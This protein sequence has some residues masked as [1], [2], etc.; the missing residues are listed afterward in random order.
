LLLTRI[1]LQ[2]LHLPIG[3]LLKHTRRLLMPNC[4]SADIKLL[5][6]TCTVLK[7]TTNSSKEVASITRLPTDVLIHS[8]DIMVGWD[9]LCC[10]NGLDSKASMRDWKSYATVLSSMNTAWRNLMVNMASFWSH[11]DAQLDD[12]KIGSLPSTLS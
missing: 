11:I 1:L 3:F 6:K 5:D 10:E 9:D 4:H 2:S 12:D 7:I 8:F